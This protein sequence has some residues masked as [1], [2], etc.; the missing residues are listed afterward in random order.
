MP[1]FSH[2]AS[3]CIPNSPAPGT[4]GIPLDYPFTDPTKKIDIMAFKNSTATTLFTLA[5]GTAIGVLIAPASGRETRR[6][7]M[8]QGSGA[9][10]TLEYLVM[11]AG[12][13]VDQLRSLIGNFS[14]SG[15][16]PNG[17]HTKIGSQAGGSS[18]RS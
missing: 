15:N 3:V 5:V 2:W 7:I 1:F 4:I 9:K 16:S 17:D 13:L 10:D 12:D 18:Q 11:E 8:E 14:R 6:K